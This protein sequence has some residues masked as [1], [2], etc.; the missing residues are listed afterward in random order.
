MH[1]W[2]RF[3]R[4]CRNAATHGV[5]FL[6]EL[7]EFIAPVIDGLRQTLDEGWSALESANARNES[8]SRNEQ[9][10]DQ[11]PDHSPVM[12]RSAAGQSGAPPGAPVR[13]WL[14]VDGLCSVDP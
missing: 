9:V 13:L 10:G 1:R 3:W 5:L 6:D 2:E 12:G 8:I 11:F 14:M 7:A 4:H